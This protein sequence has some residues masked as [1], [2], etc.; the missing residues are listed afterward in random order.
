MTIEERIKKMSLEE[1]AAYLTGKDYWYSKDNAEL[2]LP[3]FMMCD[4]P[5]GLRKQEGESDHLG[6]NKS[7]ETVCYPSASAVASTFDTELAAKLG[8]HLGE[9]CQREHVS[10]LLG[11]GLNIKRSPLGGRNFEYYSEDPYLSGKMATGY[12]KGLQSKH[13]SACPK[14]FAANN[15]ETRRM[16]GNSIVDERTLNEIY[17]T[18]FEMVVKEANPHSIMCAYNQVNGTFMAENKELLT[19]VLR[20]KWGFDGFVV[21]DWGAGKDSVKGVEAGLDLVMPGGHDAGKD[22]IVAAVQEGRLEESKVDQAVK[23]IMST[24]FWSLEGQPVKAPV[25]DDITRANDFAFARELAENAAVLLKNEK[26]I[27]PLNEKEN[28]AFI[29]AFAKTPRYQG[30]G[31][32]HINSARVVSSLEAA[33]EL[34][35]VFAEGYDIKQEDRNEALL[36]EAVKVAKEADKV[37]VFAGL[38]D[39]YESEGSDRKSLD[40]PESQNQLISELAKVNENIIVVLHNGSAIT[41]PWISE[42]KAVLGMHLA[43]DACGQATV[44]LLYGKV[45]PS[46]KLAETYPLNVAHNPS[47]LNFAEADGNPVYQEGVFVGYRYYEKKQMDV[48]FPF[49]FGLSYTSFAYDNLAIEK[50]KMTD[51]ETIKVS[52]DV[53]NTGK[54]FGKEA[55]QLYVGNAEG[56]L[57][58]AIKELKGFAKVALGPGEK[59]TVTFSLDKR[60]F[61]YYEVAIHD[62]Y[63]ES[64]KYEI[65]VGSA[66]NNIH[67]TGKIAVEGTVEIPHHFTMQ[68]T[69]G[70]ILSTTKGHA[71]LEPMMKAMTQKSDSM[72]TEALGEGSAEMAAAMAMEMPIGALI[73]LAGVP[74]EKIM[75]ILEAV[76]N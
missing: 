54:V 37:V 58:R 74:A 41:M 67:V 69:I 13:I 34:S 19:D 73:G 71:V 20:D 76:N 7:I 60:A 35:V 5:N 39:S 66:S 57:P 16:S 10:I 23:N 59:K 24:M 9:E 62:F 47:Y 55:V 29:G 64:G 56:R 26:E 14:H 17:L 75:Q 53:T 49:G 48:L 18:A 25:S 31:S 11:P 61:A 27:L 33:K 72:D 42:V 70:E 40:M 22:A 12:V 52:V 46:G 43:G 63:V 45:N 4:G 30:S 36:Q 28:V 3:A 21:T 2:Y 1:K 51:Q 38:P 32:S 6:I 44:N 68:S 8:E 65:L 50:T 15:Q